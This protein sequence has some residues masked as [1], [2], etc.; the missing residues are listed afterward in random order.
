[1]R[2][3]D[4][5][6]PGRLGDAGMTLE[7][8]PRLDPRIASALAIAGELAPGVEPPGTGADY[9][10][11]LSYCTAFEEAN[12]AQHEQMWA[13]MPD[14][15][16]VSH[17]TEVIAGV[18]GNDIV[19]HIHQPA[20]RSGPLPCIVHLHGGGMV[21][22]SAQDPGFVRWRSSLSAAGLVVVGVEFR[23]GG[24]R[25]GAHPFPAGL[26]DC[27]SAVRW[28]HDNRGQLGI[29][30]IV[31][32]GE[33]GGGNLSL[34][35]ALK[36]EREGWAD[37]IDGVYAMCPYISGAYS[38]PPDSLP[39]LREN[40]G[41]LLDGPM[42]SAL[43]RVYDPPG[44]QA[45]NPLAWPMQASVEALRGLPPHVIS[46]NE[47]DPLRDEGLT[48]Y[49]K[50]LAAGV[51]AVGRTVLGTPHAGDGSFADVVPEVFDETVHSI[52]HFAHRLA[53]RG[54]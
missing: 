52:A 14:F 50:L 12:A 7:Q 26:N 6:R 42:M 48:Y 27:A 8:D 3:V 54:T 45:D 10:A 4:C 29:G 32:S 46:V 51:S 23:N 1:M 40:D 30:S 38:D 33:S 17:G 19:L 34:A 15:A 41:Y 39:S 20:A 5:I 36:A 18:D 13:L 24:G 11:C 49:R 37:R 2:D 53:A 47:L 22:M 9:D 28:V 25:L 44:A 35:T 21:L 43:A 16:S 31:V